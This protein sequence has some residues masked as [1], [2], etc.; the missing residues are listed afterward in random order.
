MKKVYISN[1]SRVW[2]VAVQEKL[3]A[4][5]VAEWPNVSTYRDDLS[6]AKR[7]GQSKDAMTQRAYVLRLS[8]PRPEVIMFASWPVLAWDIRDLS[9]C[10][11]AAKARGASLM[12][13]DTGFVLAPDAGADELAAV[14]ADFLAKKKS[15]D[16]GSGRKIGAAASVKARSEDIKRRI[17][18]IEDDWPKPWPPTKELLDRAG[19]ERK[20]GR[21]KVWV[22][23][24]YSTAVKALK[25][26]RPKAQVAFQAGLARAEANR[27]RRKSDATE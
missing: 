13:L 15:A 1:I 18:L 21:K 23:M 22:P 2:P 6:A 20:I 7:Q 26:S 14:V 4:A 12:A 5:K 10:W 25:I 24:A 19:R 27:K 3:I 11:K 17:A 9:E 8:T 16:A